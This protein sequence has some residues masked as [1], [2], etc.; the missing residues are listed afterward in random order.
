MAAF[1][2]LTDGVKNAIKESPEWKAMIDVAQ[3]V[4]G[5]SAADDDIPF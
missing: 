4:V 2:R 3:P 5:D 1:G